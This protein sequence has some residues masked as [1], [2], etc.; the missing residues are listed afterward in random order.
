M[1]KQKF[2]KQKEGGFPVVNFT[3]NNYILKR[4]ILNFSNEISER[5]SKA[6]RKFTADITYGMLAGGSCFLTDVV[7]QLHED[8]KK[9]N[10]VDRL[11]RHMNKGIP[12]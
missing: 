5:L 3:S 8:S 9:I 11:P 10:V 7:D 12:A 6:E 2:A 4:E 1:T